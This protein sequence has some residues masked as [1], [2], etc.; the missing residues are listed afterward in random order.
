MR[1]TERYNDMSLNWNL[2]NIKN[3]EELCWQKN[4]DDTVKLNVVTESLIFIGMAI[5]IG[6]ITEDNA[7]EVFGRISMYE[8]LFGATMCVFND[9]GKE[10]V[11]ITPEDVNAHIGLS[12]NVSKETEASFRKRMTDNFMRDKKRQFEYAVKSEESE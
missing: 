6:K 2:T 7:S 4:E 11:F 8:K 9:K 5:G 3:Y 10:Q 12:T 1:L